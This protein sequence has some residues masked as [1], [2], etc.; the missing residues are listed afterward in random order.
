[1]SEEDLRKAQIEQGAAE[2]SEKLVTENLDMHA[3]EK[4]REP[5]NRPTRQ[6]LRLIGR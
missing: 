5:I 6:Y 1:M 2:L 4:M 3:V